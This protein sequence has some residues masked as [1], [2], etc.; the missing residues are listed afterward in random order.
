[1]LGPINCRL[2]NDII[3]DCRKFARSTYMRGTSA[4]TALIA[5]ADR[6]E[7]YQHIMSAYDIYFD[8]SFEEEDALRAYNGG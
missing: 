5:A 2:D 1:M 4:S 7:R 3:A 6:I 8:A